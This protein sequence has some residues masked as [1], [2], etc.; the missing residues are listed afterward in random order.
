MCTRPTDDGVQGRPSTLRSR[1][2]IGVRRAVL[3]GGL[4]VA[5][6]VVANWLNEAS[7]AA[8]CGGQVSSPAGD[9]RGAAPESP[10]ASDVLTGFARQ[11]SQVL[12]PADPQIATID[13]ALP[14]ALD[15]AC[16]A[17]LGVLP[18]A[19]STVLTSRLPS[20]PVD[21]G[22]R[23]DGVTRAVRAVVTA[24]PPTSVAGIG[25]VSHS[26]TVAH[27]VESIMDGRLSPGPIRSRST[28]TGTTRQLFAPVPRKSMAASPLPAQIPVPWAPTNNGPGGSAPAGL[29][30]SGASTTS[31]TGRG[32]GSVLGAVLPHGAARDALPASPDGSR[33]EVYPVRQRANDPAVSPD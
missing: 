21:V 3:L 33:Y 26:G 27:V 30:T 5:G 15:S 14:D 20:L 19:D 28:S 7:A 1:V 25:Q 24:L 29:V 8:D 12:L 32:G 4:V 23:V 31:S 10:D 22:R 11:V 2:L 16:T 13:G 6:F 18:S 9:V 17:V